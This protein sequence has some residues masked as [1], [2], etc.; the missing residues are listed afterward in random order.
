[1]LLYVDSV[2]CKGI[3]EERSFATGYWT[4][5]R[6]QLREDMEIEQGGL[7]EEISG[8]NLLLKE[9]LMPWQVKKLTRRKHKVKKVD[10][11]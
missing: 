8:D 6:L 5:Q 11:V 10:Q 1:M 2:T 9:V 3:N 7:E 4:T